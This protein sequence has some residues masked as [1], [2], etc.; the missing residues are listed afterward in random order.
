MPPR[1][2][3]IDAY[4]IDEATECWVW[5]GSR[6]WNGYGQGSFPGCQSRL[7]HRYHYEREYGPI[8][9]GMHLD[10]LC[11]NRGC[12]NP[13]HLEVVTN[14][15][16]Q[17]RGSHTLLTVEQVREIKAAPRVRGSGNQLAKRF[18]VHE[19]TI[20]AI[21]HGRL[22]PDVTVGGGPEE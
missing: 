20:S 3:S 12:V 15:E 22:W 6:T 2:H 10:H 4:G 19:C 11:R 8:P 21:R 17:R 1:K 9:A 13:A 7:A 18:G 14:K 5:Q 16:N